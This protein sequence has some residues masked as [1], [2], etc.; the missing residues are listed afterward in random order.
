M[1]SAHGKSKERSKQQL[2]DDEANKTTLN[3]YAAELE[4]MKSTLKQFLGKHYKLEVIKKIAFETSL[5]TKIRIERRD[6]R[7]FDM[8]ICW[9]AKNWD[10][11]KNEFTENLFKYLSE[12]K[13]TETNRIRSSDSSSPEQENIGNFEKY[14]NVTFYLNEPIVPQNSEISMSEIIRTPDIF[15]DKFETISDEEENHEDFF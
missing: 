3:M 13:D 5:K 15:A 2:R 14:E 7:K 1:I 12:Q 6:R 4:S 8:L 10:L 9:V 11:I